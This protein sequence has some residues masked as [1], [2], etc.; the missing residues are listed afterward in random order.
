MRV[1]PDAAGTSRDV[2]SAGLVLTELTPCASAI[3]IFLFA[4]GHELYLVG[5]A[6]CLIAGAA[7]IRGPAAAAPLGER[8]DCAE[9]ALPPVG[10]AGERVLTA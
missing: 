9:A 10:F 1:R 2:A 6:A 5:V 3:I 7:T 8:Q 4:L